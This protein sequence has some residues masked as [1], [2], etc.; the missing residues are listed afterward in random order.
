MD[1]GNLKELRRALVLKQHSVLHREIGRIDLEHEV[2]CDALVLLA[3][4]ARQRED[5]GFV[6]V[7]VRVE[8][9]RGDDARRDRQGR[10]ETFGTP[11]SHLERSRFGS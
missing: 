10:C 9:R 2:P 8:Q 1:R 7:V 4:L 5:V 11:T 3:H 6:A